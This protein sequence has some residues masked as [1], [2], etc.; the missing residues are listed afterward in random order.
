MTCTWMTQAQEVTTL[1]MM[2]TLTQGPAQ[3]RHI[4][5]HALTDLGK[6]T[7]TCVLSRQLPRGVMAFIFM[8]AAGKFF[9]NVKLFCCAITSSLLSLYRS[10]SFSSLCLFFLYFAAFYLSLTR[11]QL[12]FPCHT[13]S[14][15]KVCKFHVFFIS[16]SNLLALSTLAILILCQE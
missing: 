6:D 5:T 10:S 4:S 2:M 14:L 9:T 13:D 11:F 7:Y 8:S 1:R 12:R 16:S 15:G 3:V